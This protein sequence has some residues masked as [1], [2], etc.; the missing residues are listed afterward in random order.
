MSYSK[1][2]VPFISKVRRRG[3]IVAGRAY[4]TFR[5]RLSGRT[6]WVDHD[7][8]RLPFH[9]DGDY[10]EVDYYLN[11]K[12]FWNYELGVVSR[13]LC[14][15]DVAVDVGANMGFLAGMFSNLTGTAG[16]VYS[17]EPSPTTY[18]K[19]LEV[20]KA[21]NYTN[22][23]PFNMGCGGEDGLM[24]L[25][26]P[27]SS[28]NATL[29]PT[30]AMNALAL[31]VQTVRIVKL[32]DFL[33]PKL[34]RLNFLKVDVEDYEDEVLA[35]AVGLLDRFKP[36]VYIEL[37]QRNIASSKAAVQILRDRGYTFDPEVTLEKDSDQLNYFALPPGYQ[38]RL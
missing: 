36:V 26:Q 28:G 32:D 18:V 13:Y 6:L 14:H 2:H 4:L 24:T 19:L 7:C 1:S 20:I 15:G 8:I 5:R 3:R 23:S 37:I 9:G 33:A 38:G 30:A 10:Q 12:M 31:K 22:V 35:G 29:R 34:E 21:N 17:F 27:S 25:Y 11:A 16:H